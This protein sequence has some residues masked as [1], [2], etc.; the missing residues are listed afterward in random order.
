MHV[1]IPTYPHTRIPTYIHTHTHTH[2]YTHTHTH[3][4]IHTHIGG[5][6]AQTPPPTHR[7]DQDKRAAETRYPVPRLAAHLQVPGP[8]LR[9][10]FRPPRPAASVGCAPGSLQGARRITRDLACDARMGV[11]ERC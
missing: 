11:V 5:R 2:T 4:Y 3:T 1:H 8:S 9:A 6:R 10:A 7:L